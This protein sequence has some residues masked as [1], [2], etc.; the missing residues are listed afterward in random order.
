MDVSIVGEM[1]DDERQTEFEAGAP[2]DEEE[3][4]DGLTDR[5]KRE[6]AKRKRANEQA[7]KLR[8]EVESL[9]RE[10]Q[11][12]E[13]QEL[14]E[15]DRLRQDY[16]AAKV[17]LARAQETA[18]WARIESAAVRLGFADPE[19][20]R[21]IDPSIL[22]EG[23][24]KDVDLALRDLLERKPHLKAQ[25]QAAVDT[26]AGGNPPGSAAAR[27]GKTRDDELRQRF[28]LDA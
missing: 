23:T 28:K 25:P 6:I 5:E 4:G 19:D 26:P 17:E 11:E 9:K 12:R 24:A 14:S 18:L 21:L 22:G 27:L 15:L 20:S 10:K 3:D 16:D 13:R 7:A 2:Q 1:S 8:V